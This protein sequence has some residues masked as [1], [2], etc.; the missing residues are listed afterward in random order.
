MGTALGAPYGVTAALATELGAKTHVGPLEPDTLDLYLRARQTMRTGW[1]RGAAEA[2]QMLEQVLVRNPDEP[3]ALAVYA[4][5]LTRKA[6]FDQQEGAALQETLTRVRQCA[7]RAVARAP[8][9]GD[10]WL[11]LAT[12]NLYTGAIPDAARALREAV[13]RAPGLSRAQQMLGGMALEVGRPDEAIERLQ[14]ALSIDPDAVQAR[15]DLVRAY[16]YSGRWDAADTLLDAGTRQMPA[17]NVLAFTSARLSI[18]AP[19][20]SLPEPDLRADPS[21]SAMM[22]GELMTWYRHIREH[23]TQ[24]P[25][26]DVTELDTFRGDLAL[27]RSVRAQIGAEMFCYVGEVGKAVDAVTRAVAAGL[28]DVNWMDRCPVLGPA[29][30]HRAWPELHRAVAGRAAEIRAAIEGR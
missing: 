27:L 18:W 5:A 3:N 8:E 6:F 28:Y 14:A 7:N 26:L 29:R 9:F 13:R 22:L 19:G 4:M 1:D 16:A 10:A 24:P 2:V 25:G 11:A 30:S 21:P 15:G 12:A 23:H 20:R 17:A